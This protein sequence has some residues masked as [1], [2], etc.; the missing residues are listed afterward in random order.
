LKIVGENMESNKIVINTLHAMSWLDCIKIAT[1]KQM[2]S[3]LI[4]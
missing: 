1:A 3:I 2:C 4:T